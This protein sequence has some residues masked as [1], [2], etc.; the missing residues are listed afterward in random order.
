[1]QAL[2]FIVS[3]REGALVNYLHLSGT[4]HSLLE[5]ASFFLLSV[6]DFCRHLSTT[7][8]KWQILNSDL[9]AEFIF[10]EYSE[11]DTVCE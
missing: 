5:A 2:P 4:P 3:E 10:G 7:F 6:T 9:V 8:E 1:M 11:K